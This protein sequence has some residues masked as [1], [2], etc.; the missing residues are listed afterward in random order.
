MSRNVRRVA[1]PTSAI[2]EQ[3]RRN[4]RPRSSTADEGAP[5][6]ERRRATVGDG[7]SPLRSL[8]G[9]F[10]GFWRFL[11]WS[12]V[13]PS[14]HPNAKMYRVESGKSINQIFDNLEDVFSGLE[15]IFLSLDPSLIVGF[16][17]SN[18]S[19]KEEGNHE[20]YCISP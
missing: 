12:G 13:S 11:N 20:S 10:L 7:V 16:R 5:R 2:A 6:E 3:N 9:I 19:E 4:T 15:V 17:T 1:T 14:K 8:W 18:L